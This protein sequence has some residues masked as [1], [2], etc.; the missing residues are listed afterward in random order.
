MG[1]SP[2]VGARSTTAVNTHLGLQAPV[3]SLTKTVPARNRGEQMIHSYGGSEDVYYLTHLPLG[4]ATLYLSRDVGGQREVWALRSSLD[5][6][7]NISSRAS[8]A[9]LASAVL[10]SDPAGN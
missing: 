8:D 10:G 7:G 1:R 9:E 6:T 5:V 2:M 3:I 4:V